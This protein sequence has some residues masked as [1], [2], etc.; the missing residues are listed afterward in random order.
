MVAELLSVS[1]GWEREAEQA[2]IHDAILVV[3]CDES[4][5]DPRVRSCQPEVH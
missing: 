3:V 1:I 2:G 4:P 5:T